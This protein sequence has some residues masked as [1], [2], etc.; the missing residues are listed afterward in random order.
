MQ[1]TTI[2]IIQQMRSKQL[3]NQRKKKTTIKSYSK[4]ETNYY[5]ILQRTRNKLL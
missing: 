4:H 3:E 1:Q 5:K 2:K